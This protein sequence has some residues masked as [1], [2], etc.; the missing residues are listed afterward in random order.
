MTGERSDLYAVLGLTPQATQQQVRHA[1]RTLL[2]QNHPDTRPLSAPAEH[3]ASH[4]TLQQA[5]AAYT[6]R[7]TRPAGPATTSAPPSRRPPE[8]RFAR[9]GS[10]RWAIRNSRQ[11]RPGQCA[12]T[13][14]ADQ[15][16]VGSASARAKGVAM[17][18]KR[19]RDQPARARPRQTCAPPCTDCSFPRDRTTSSPHSWSAAPRPGCY[20]VRA[21]SR[22]SGCISGSTRCAPTWLRVRWL[23][24]GRSHASSR[25]RIPGPPSPA[26]HY[27]SGI[28]QASAG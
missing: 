3:A 13:A 5:I 2:R 18:I 23:A 4:T 10:S 1:Y 12:G 26:P 27:P 25:P 15:S 24:D 7:E 22:G 11:S 19:H 20:G 16:R 8:A 21:A 17:T 28:A 6:A 9:R 14:A